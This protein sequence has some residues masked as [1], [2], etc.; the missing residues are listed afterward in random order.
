MIVGVTGGIGAGKS[1]VCQTFLDLGGFVIDA[2]VVGHET[3]R[4]PEVIL[5]LSDGFG[6]D[7]LD[8]HGQVLRPVLG[9]MAFSSAAQRDKLNV[10]VWPPLRTLLRKKIQ[11]A[12]QED[13]KR[14]VVVDAALLIERGNPRDLVD[15]L[16]VVSAPDDIRVRR[17]VKRLGISVTEVKDRMA[18]QLPQADKMRVADF[19]IRNDSTPDVC[20]QRAK[21]IWQDILNRM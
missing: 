6:A 11:E 18:A 21:G 14:P 13:P 2:D 4:D 19:V 12:Q 8:K 16:V 1:T 17:T 3:L 9:Q 10:I 15:I 20:R 5:K 7:I